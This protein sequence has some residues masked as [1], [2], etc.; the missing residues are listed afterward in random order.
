[1]GGYITT[2]T[3]VFQ[4]SDDK[5]PGNCPNYDYDA[6]PDGIA[7]CSLYNSKSKGV[8]EC[9]GHRDVDR[10]RALTQF[11]SYGPGSVIDHAQENGLRDGIKAELAARRL[12][13]WYKNEVPA[14][15]DGS[16]VQA[17]HLLEHQQENVIN[18]CVRKLA[19]IVNGKSDYGIGPK[20]DPTSHKVSTGDVARAEDLQ[21]LERAALDSY[22][23]CV[24]Y[25]DCTGHGMKTTTT[26]VWCASYGDS[27]D[28]W[29]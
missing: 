25:S 23:D 19:E 16:P 5:C 20:V 17:K 10:D 13:A 12:H 8:A 14:Q 22:R 27:G 1:M 6:D 2:T 21:F 15:P 3:K 4:H 28:G 11:Q 18:E 26:T 29:Y 7:V 9:S 24:C